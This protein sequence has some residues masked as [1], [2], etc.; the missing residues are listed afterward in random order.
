MRITYM[1]GQCLKKY[2]VNNFKWINNVS[3]TNEKFINNY[4]EDSDK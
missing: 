1:V 2:P 3:E 4:D